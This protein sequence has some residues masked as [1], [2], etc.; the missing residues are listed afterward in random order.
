MERER[1]KTLRLYAELR[2]EGK[3]ITFCKKVEFTKF[4]IKLSV[5]SFIESCLHAFYKALLVV[6]Y[7]QIDFHC[8]FDSTLMNRMFCH[9]ISERSVPLCICISSPLLRAKFN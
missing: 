9:S 2:V 1:E 6:I 3:R 4:Y 8:M 5:S 7:S